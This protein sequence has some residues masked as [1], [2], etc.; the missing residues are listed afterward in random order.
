[1]NKES[2]I[3]IAK[4]KR[5]LLSYSAFADAQVFDGE[6]SEER[7][8]GWDQWRDD[9]LGLVL[10]YRGS[11]GWIF[12]RNSEARFYGHRKVVWDKAASLGFFVADMD[13]YMTGFYLDEE[14]KF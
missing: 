4:L 9:T 10:V 8:H 2:R 5:W 6:E 11:G 7:I 12:G 13:D 1:M 14:G 3:Q